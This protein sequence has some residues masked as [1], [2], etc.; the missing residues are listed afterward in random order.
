MVTVFRIV[1]PP[2]G[3]EITGDGSS[4]TDEEMAQEKEARQAF[5]DAVSPYLAALPARPPHRSGNVSDVELLGGDVWS[6]LNQYL[7]LVNVDIGDPRIDFDSFM[8]PGTTVTRVAGDLVPLS[9]WPD[10]DLT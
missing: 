7:L 2:T 3:I 8:P 5:L 1:A 10:G 6:Q 9:Q 4:P